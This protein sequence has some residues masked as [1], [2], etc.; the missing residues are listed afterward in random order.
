MRKATK[1]NA[2]AKY[3]VLPV[4]LTTAQD[5]II[6]KAAKRSDEKKSAF[7]RAAALKRAER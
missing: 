3:K 4:R 2:A 1:K 6:A 5:R 7:V